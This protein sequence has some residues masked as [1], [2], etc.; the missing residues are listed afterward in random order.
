MTR[1]TRLS[2]KQLELYRMIRNPAGPQ[3]V[4]GDGAVRSGKSKTA[5][6]ALATYVQESFAGHTCAL[7]FRSVKQ[8]EKI[9]QAEL[10]AWCR[11][12]GSRWRKTAGGIEVFRPDGKSNE[13]LR[14]LG[15]DIS[16]VDSVQGLTLC[17]AFVD[18]APL[19][20][21][22]F[23]QELSFR[24][25]VPGSKLVM[26]CNPAGGKRHWFYATYIQ[27]SHTDP[28]RGDYIRFTA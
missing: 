12:T 18:E 4:V 21:E 11:E 13:F 7:A 15:K 19:Q 10:L 22:D 2:A 16:S 6:Y 8:Y 5:I 1:H 25:S 20:P 3:L 23:V 14:V 28:S 9:G 24:C 27:P 17:A 26:V